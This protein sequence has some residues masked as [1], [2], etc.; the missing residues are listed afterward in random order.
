[1]N[2]YDFL[3]HVYFFKNLA[4]EELRM[5]LDQCAESRFLAG[6]HICDEGSPADSFHILVEGQVQVYKLD[7]DGQEN[8][9]AVH[10][11]GNF[12]GEM[13]LIDE[14]PRSATIIAGENCLLLSLSRDAFQGLIK[15]NTAIALSIMTSLSKVVRTSNESFV[16]DLKRRNTELEQAY[17]ALE[18]AQSEQL[19]T[20]RLSTLGKFSSMILHD[21]RNPISIIKGQIQLVSLHLNEPERARHYLKN[22]EGEAQRLENL[23]NEFLD[24]ARGEIRLDFS[25][26]Q[27]SV[28]LEACLQGLRPLL[29]SKGIDL[30]LDIEADQAVFIDTQRMQRA[31]RNI[32]DNAIKALSDCDRKRL[33]I[34][35]EGDEERFVL[36][37]QDSGIGIHQNLL[38]QIF[39]PFFTTSSSGGTGLGLHIVKSI[40]EAHKG[41]LSVE[42]TPEHGSC[43][44]IELPRR[45]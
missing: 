22:I 2:H 16:E 30:E 28:L 34:K 10:G 42:S 43:F 27:P 18:N 12:F 29:Q 33:S 25:L 38:Q 31:I 1:M 24:F 4:D 45:A 13:A 6:Q 14:L 23:A 17:Q 19:R 3:R 37:I 7:H 41:Q 40:I 11:P 21:I 44:R 35:A 39:D 26:I 32:L 5:V 20:A 36:R 8:L 9:L 15:K